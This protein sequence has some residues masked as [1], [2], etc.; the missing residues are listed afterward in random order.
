MPNVLEIFVLYIFY[1]IL[2]SIKN[3][4]NNFLHHLTSYINNYIRFYLKNVKT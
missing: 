2:I 3:K 1:K 4:R